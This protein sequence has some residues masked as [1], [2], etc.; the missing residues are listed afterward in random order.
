MSFG[1]C[2]DVEVVM[3]GVCGGLCFACLG[4]RVER[5]KWLRD[6]RGNALKSDRVAAA[7]RVAI[8]E[9]CLAIYY[10]ALCANDNK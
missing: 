6:S 2:G 9:V 4:R 1:S 5:V 8:T 3:C 10:T 7:L